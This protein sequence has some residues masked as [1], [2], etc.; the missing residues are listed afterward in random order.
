MIA[1]CDSGTPVMGEKN[2]ISPD[3]KIR[4]R[5]LTIPPSE[6][7]SVDFKLF[8]LASTGVTSAEPP[9]SRIPARDAPR[10]EW[11]RFAELNDR[12]LIEPLRQ[13]KEKYA[14]DIVDTE[15]AGI[16]VGVI[17]PEGG[18]PLRNEQRVL[19]N[20]HGGGF[21]YYRGLSFGLLESIPIA[22]IGKIKVITIDYRQA[23]FFEYPAASE[24]V[25]LIYREVLSRYGAQAV[26]IFGCSAGGALAAQVLAR[27]QA[28]GVQRPGA[29]GI[30]NFAPPVA[31]WP[32]G[33]AGDSR[34]WLGNVP[35]DELSETD[36]AIVQPAQWY[37][38][39]A[40]VNDPQAYP[41]SSDSVLAQF[42]ATLLLTGTRE[43]WF[44]PA[45]AAHT[46]LLKLA[47]DSSLYV[48]EGAWHMAHVLAVRTPEAH[49]ANAYI[50]RWFDRHLAS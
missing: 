5:E 29:V 18:V 1:A 21:V 38:E 7:W 17:T 39:H 35:K 48:M 44:S 13:A 10:A 46:R 49:D 11:D 14:V 12:H 36:R 15:L 47:V 24:D 26:G 27:L 20:L 8:F 16:H 32:W 4:I 19:I 33:K 42:P 45:V 9:F 2:Q 28:K 34:V 31:P 50:A 3:G 43:C 37:M 23:P 6:F 22:A 40:D 41:G 30:H 25:E